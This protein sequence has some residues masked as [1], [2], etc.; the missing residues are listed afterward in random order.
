MKATIFSNL[1]FHLQGVPS[2]Y[3]LYSNCILITSSLL[4]ITL[5]FLLL[6]YYLLF[7]AVSQSGFLIYMGSEE[8]NKW[9][10]CHNLRG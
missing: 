8:K 2:L 3:Y 6:T 1:N 10:K 9:R 5:Y 4:L 7:A